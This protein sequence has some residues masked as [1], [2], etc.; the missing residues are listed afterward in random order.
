MAVLRLANGS[1]TCQ[2]SE[3]FQQGWFPQRR[4]FGARGARL[5]IWEHVWHGIRD[6][7]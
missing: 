1:K 3:S 7:A 6:L 2:A 4:E 5:W